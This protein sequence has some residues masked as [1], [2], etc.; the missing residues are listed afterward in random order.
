MNLVTGRPSGV[1]APASRIASTPAIRTGVG[2]G[3][4]GLG[5]ALGL[6]VVVEVVTATVVRS[7]YFPRPSEVFVAL[8]DQ[9]AGGELGGAIASTLGTF[10]TGLAIAA[11][12]GVL[13]G[14]PLGSFPRLYAVFSLVIEFLRPLPSVA[15]IPFVILLL[16]VGSPTAITVTAYAAFW[17]VLFNTYYGVRDADP[18]AIDTARNFGLTRLEV[19]RRVVL[20]MAARN[21]ATGLRVSSAIALILTITVELLTSSGGVGYFITFMQGAT[22]TTEMYAGVVAVGVL[23]YLVNLALRAA[24]RRVVFWH[25]DPTEKAV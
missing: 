21:V 15:L 1:D 19:L 11:A 7:R 14:V 6:I 25:R 22:R 4:R 23:G 10:V 5:F 2:R 17:P 12:A 8:A 9:L 13:L 3:A 24:E 18:V 20:P 16:G